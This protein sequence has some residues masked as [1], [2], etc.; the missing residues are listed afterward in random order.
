MWCSSCQQDVPALGAPGGLRCGK[1][2]TL[3]V[4]QGELLAGRS[5]ATPAEATAATSLTNLLRD[6]PLGEDDWVLEAELRGVERLVRSLK[7]SG[8][9]AK[10]PLAVDAPHEAAA[11]WHTAARSP[12]PDARKGELEQAVEPPKNL[13]AWTIVSLG[14]AVFPAAL[15]CWHGRLL[16]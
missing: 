5:N 13:A 11:G 2:N 10:Q 3:F 8:S 14:L 9:L 7:S 12:A 6:S 15:C 16:P 1:C 4:E